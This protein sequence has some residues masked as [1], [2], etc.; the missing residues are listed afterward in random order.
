MTAIAR[1]CA[2][3][4]LEWTI[5]RIPFLSDKSGDLE[6][7]AGFYGPEFKGTSRLSR[8]SLARWVYAEIAKRE[9]VGKEPALGNP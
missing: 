2:D 7:V 4:D 1:V 9:W 6:V 3:P 5:F 8:A